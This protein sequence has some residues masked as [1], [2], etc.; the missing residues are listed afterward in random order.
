MYGAAALADYDNDGYLDAITVG[1]GYGTNLYHNDGSDDISPNTAPTVPSAL[2][3]SIDDDGV[4]T[5]TWTAST[6]AE[7]SSLQYNLY[8]KKS[9]DTFATF[10]LPAD[11]TTGK[12]KVNENLAGLVTTSYRISGLPEG[13]YT[14]GVS[15]IDN[16]KMASA[17]ATQ[18]FT[19]PGRTGINHQQLSNKTPQ[20]VQYFDLTGKRIAAGTEG[21]VIKKTT[22]N[23]GSVQN[24]K[25]II[26]K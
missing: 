25:E 16:G 7:G 14:F 11:E 8:V 21:F 18:Q 1:E 17:F 3:A 2:A 4:V 20:S 15:A 5:F 24:T 12:L 26:V 22:Y 13:E 6:D 9:D 10:L 23:D 19:V